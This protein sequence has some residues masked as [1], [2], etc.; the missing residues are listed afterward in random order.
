MT[1][2]FL[3]RTE[4]TKAHKVASRILA[5]LYTNPKQE[6]YDRIFYGNDFT[7]D[8][9]VH[10]FER[11]LETTADFESFFLKYGKYEFVPNP[12]KTT[13]LI[14]LKFR[15]IITRDFVDTICQVGDGQCINTRAQE[16]LE[17]YNC[18]YRIETVERLILKELKKLGNHPEDIKT[19]FHEIE[20]A[21]I[22]DAMSNCK[23]E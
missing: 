20:L 21:K 10:R 4:C 6:L 15:G 18:K 3:N 9:L 14:V 12:W 23:I 11:Y 22:A 19:V 2:L 5:S 1:D 16:I 17:K 8:E 13:D 7:P